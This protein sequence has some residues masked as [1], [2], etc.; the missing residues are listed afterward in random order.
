MSETITPAAR[1]R[2]GT[3]GIARAGGLAFALLI[4]TATLL[5]ASPPI[6]AQAACSGNA[7]VCENQL[8]GTPESVWDINGDGDASIQGF[9]TKT[10]VNAG[11]SID[12]KINTTAKAYTIKIYR[13]G[14]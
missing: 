3:F 8:L 14:W 12:F 13:L 11:A 9:A 1:R 5:L 6:L 4:A 2:F 10:S 7:I